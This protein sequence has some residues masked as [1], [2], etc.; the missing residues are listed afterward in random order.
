[1]KLLKRLFGFLEP[2]VVEDDFFGRLIYIKAKK[3]YG[4]D[5]WEGK[6]RFGST[7][8]AV[9]VFVDA[10]AEK[11][12]P[13]TLQRQFFQDV[14]SRYSSLLPTL[15]SLLVT[16]CEKHGLDKVPTEVSTLNIAAFTIPLPENSRW[17]IMLESQ[18][19]AYH[20]T[21]NMDGWNATD[22]LVDF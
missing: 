18:D 4:P 8:R 12:P 14:E 3:G 22:V 13:N 19:T 15:Q 9:E 1:M 20:Y 21:V 10:P 5:Y 17:N 11:M 7:N 16:Y 2:Y 6:K